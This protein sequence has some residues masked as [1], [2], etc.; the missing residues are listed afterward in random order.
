MEEL[1]GEIEILK[2]DQIDVKKRGN[3]VFAELD[4]RRTM[5]E[6]EY[7]TLRKKYESFQ[8]DYEEKKKELDR[9]RVCLSTCILLKMF[10][11]QFSVSDFIM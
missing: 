4:D 2:F 10:N 1:Q 9:A 6:R 7:K 11:F 5:V 3:S 8:K